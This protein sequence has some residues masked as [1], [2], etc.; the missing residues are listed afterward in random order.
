MY[1]SSLEEKEG[2]PISWL[3]VIEKKESYLPRTRLTC[4]PHTR[5]TYLP[6][7]SLQGPYAEIQLSF[8]SSGG[9]VRGGVGSLWGGAGVRMKL[10]GSARHPAMLQPLCFFTML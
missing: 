7:I 2:S 8:Y 3:T 6:H 1:L 5:L 4:L 9:G 10:Q